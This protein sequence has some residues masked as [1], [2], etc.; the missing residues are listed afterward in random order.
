V[1]QLKKTQLEHLKQQNTAIF[2]DDVASEKLKDYEMEVDRRCQELNVL[3]NRLHSIVMH[4]KT[5]KSYGQMNGNW[6]Q[7]QTQARMVS[8]ILRNI[9]QYQVQEVVALTQLFRSCQ[10]VYFER[11]NEATKVDPEFV[12]TFDNDLLEEELTNDNRFVKTS[13][14]DDS[15]FFTNGPDNFHNHNSTQQQQQLQ[16][17]LDDQIKM[18]HSI[19]EH[20]REREREMNSIMKSFVELNQLFQEIQTL[21]VDQG[22][23]LDRIDF[24]IE[25]VEHRVELGAVSLEKAHQSITRVRKLKLILGAGLFLFLLFIFLIIRS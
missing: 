5:L 10:R 13:F 8:N 6:K 23:A 20:L 21:V 22:S 1:E 7:T 19:N 15:V 12:I 24:N 14:D 25:Q 18:D 4:F 2:A 16:I 11:R 17:S 9:F 3:F